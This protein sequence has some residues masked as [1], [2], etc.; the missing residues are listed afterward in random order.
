M[1]LPALTPDLPPAASGHI[2]ITPGVCGGKPRLAGTRIRVQDV[3]IWYERMDLSADEIASKHPQAS[4]AAIHA[5]L[6][7]YHD[8]QAEIDEQMRQSDEVVEQLR[9]AYPTKLPA[10]Q[11]PQA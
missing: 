3:V 11:R 4:L 6:S 8:H 2:E 1:S 10:R 7:Y 5:A 9:S